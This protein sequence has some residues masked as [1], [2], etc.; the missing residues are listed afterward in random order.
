MSKSHSE[1]VAEVRDLRGQAKAILDRADGDLAGAAAEQFDRLTADIE[2]RKR[3]ME[4]LE[5]AADMAHDYQL[6]TIRGAAGRFETEGGAVGQHRI[7]G[8]RDAYI[9]DAEDRPPADRQR[10]GAMRVLDRAVKAERL[11]TR[12]AELVEGLMGTGP[13]LSQTWTQR[14][15]AATGSEAYELAFCKKL[16]DPENGQLT[17]TQ[18]EADAWRAVTAVQVEQRAMSLTDTAGGFLIPMTLDPAVLLT[19]NGSTNPLRQISRVVQIATD[20]WNGVTSAGVTAEWIAEATEV[21]D[22]SPTLAQPSIPVYKGDAFVPFSFE[23]Q[24]DAPTF[25]QE[26]AMLLQDGADQLT[27]T[28]YTTGSGIGQPTGLITKLVA[29]AGTVPLITP[30]SSETLSAA[31]PYTVQNALPPRFQPRA[32]WNANL[33]TINSLRQFETT[34][35]AL[36]FPSLQNDP[37][38]LL[39][40]TMYENSNMDGTIN[41]A[42]TENNY[43]LVYGD[44]GA[45]FTI[46]DRLGSTLELVPHLV[47]SNRRPTGQRGALLW[48]RTGSDVVIPQ[49]FRLLSIPTTA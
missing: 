48:F 49:A 16:A 14:W 12:G 29:V 43:P 1:L 15:A 25:M 13:V 46:V 24:G 27:A 28:A 34:N 47:G 42:A 19:S 40:R 10:D 21:A 36:K 9:I 11:S 26:L 39:G 37:P 30:G 22:A 41:A 38:R 17:W 7:G 3:Q 32:V 8:Q 20:V 44:F 23:V 2:D 31:D 5:H 6:A 33:S 45:G 35:G 18:E 4:R